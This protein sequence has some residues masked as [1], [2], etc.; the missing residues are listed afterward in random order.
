MCDGRRA[1]VG[2]AGNGDD[3]DDGVTRMARMT[4]VVMV[5]MIDEGPGVAALTGEV[6]LVSFCSF[7]DP[8]RGGG[9]PGGTTPAAPASAM[10]CGGALPAEDADVT[11]PTS[12]VADI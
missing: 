4:V 11:S 6:L 10:A 12:V 8:L 5:V 1:T 9:T 3:C 7:A 2:G